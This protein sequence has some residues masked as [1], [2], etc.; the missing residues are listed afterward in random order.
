MKRLAGLFLSLALLLSACVSPTR[1][2]VLSQSVPSAERRH[3][4]MSAIHAPA[5]PSPQI[6]ARRFAPSL[7]MLCPP[8]CDFWLYYSCVLSL[9][10]L[11]AGILSL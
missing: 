5:M 2:G 8:Q 10:Q 1:G 11:Y 6:N 7:S 9:R 3:I 4:A